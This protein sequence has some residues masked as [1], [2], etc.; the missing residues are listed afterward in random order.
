MKARS[1]QIR[2]LEAVLACTLLLAGHFMISHSRFSTESTRNID[3]ENLGQNLLNA[4]E[5]QE[6]ILTR[7]GN[8]DAWE[9]S[10]KELIDALIPP[11][12]IYRISLESLVTGEKIAE[13]VTN[14]PLAG[15]SSKSSASVQGIYTFSYPLMT[16][17][18]LL[19][20]VIMVVDRSGSMD[21]AITGDPYNKIYYAQLA[22]S[23]FVNRLNSTTD[24]VGLVSFSSSSRNFSYFGTRNSPASATFFSAHLSSS[25]GDRSKTFLS[26]R[27]ISRFLSVRISKREFSKL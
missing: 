11:D 8:K 22:A 10:L 24:M 17:E 12:L 3:L 9:T 25:S 27:W 14:S 21:D 2:I 26:N 19:L 6:L 5:D 4:L 1:G 15:H 20:D 13:N 23:N 18:D 7:E 16:G